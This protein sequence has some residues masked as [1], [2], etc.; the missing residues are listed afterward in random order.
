MQNKL[1]GDAEAGLFAA[2]RGQ[3]HRHDAQKTKRGRGKRKVWEGGKEDDEGGGC[4]RKDLEERALATLL[5]L[6]LHRGVEDS[7]DGLIKD[8]LETLLCE[9]RAL[10]V[11]VRVDLLGLCCALLVGDGAALVLLAQLL[12][13]VLVVAQIELRADQHDGHLCAVVGHLREPLCRHVLNCVHEKNKDKKVKRQGENVKKQK[14]G[15]G[16]QQT[17]RRADDREADEEDVSLGV[18]E[19]AETVVIFLTGSIPETQVDGLAIDHHVRAVVVKHSRD[20][21]AVLGEETHNSTGET[22][23]KKSP[24]NI[25]IKRCK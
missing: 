24:Q 1:R 4:L 10:E 14:G 15:R 5:L 7:A 20:V 22:K 9:R 2:S 3:T 16:L 12:D 23:K 13:G 11:L 6:L 19:R 25:N 8:L 21:L 17:G 18:R